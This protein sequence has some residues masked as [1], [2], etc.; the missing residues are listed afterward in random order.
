MQQIVIFVLQ[1]TAVKYVNQAIISIQINVIH[2][3]ISLMGAYYAILVIAY[4]VNQV[5][6]L[7]LQ[8]FHAIIA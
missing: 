4:L 1:Q 2:V 8:L 7:I 5:F 3:L 6:I